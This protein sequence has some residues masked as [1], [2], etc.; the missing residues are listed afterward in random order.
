M[1]RTPAIALAVVLMATLFTAPASAATPVTTTYTSGAKAGFFLNGRF[2]GMLRS[3]SGGHAVGQLTKRTYDGQTRLS[4]GGVSV[5]PLSIEV[6]LH[7]DRSL[8]DWIA[9]SVS[10]TVKPARMYRWSSSI[11]R[12]TR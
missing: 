5:E 3:S 12:T 2:V 11:L 6:G 4:L 8:Y 10:S 9:A 1:S 7:L